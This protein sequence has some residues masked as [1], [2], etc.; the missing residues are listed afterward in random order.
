MAPWP[1]TASEWAF[2][3][4]FQR[5]IAWGREK[6][7][8]LIDT[9]SEILGTTIWAKFPVTQFFD[10]APAPSPLAV[11]L[12]YPPTNA[13]YLVDGLQRLAVATAILSSL[14]QR[15][16]LGTGGL[17]SIFPRLSQQISLGDA[18]IVRFN[19]HVLA[20]YPRPA[21][22]QQY[23]DF[24]RDMDSWVQE[25]C[26]QTSVWPAQV[27]AFFL[28]RQVGVDVYTG[29]PTPAA[30]ASNFVGIN[31]GSQQLGMEDIFRAQIVEDGLTNEW[32]PSDALNFDTALTDAL[33]E[34]DRAGRI[35]PLV[36]QLGKLTIQKTRTRSVPSLGKG[37]GAG[38]R[39]DT[40]E[41]IDR[42][43]P[44]CDSEVTPNPYDEAAI[45]ELY[46][47][48]KLPLSL[49]AA[50]DIDALRGAPWYLSTPPTAPTQDLLLLLRATYRLYIV[51][52]EGR[53][54][55]LLKALLEDDGA[56]SPDL[57]ALAEKISRA[58]T[59]TPA[60]TWKKVDDQVDPNWLRVRLEAIPKRRA[61][62]VFAACELEPAFTASGEPIQPRPATFQPQPFGT[63]NASL[64]I[65]HL[66]P[67]SSAGT[68][69]NAEETLRNFAP[70]P[71]ALNRSLTSSPCSAKLQG[72]P[73]APAGYK[74]LV[75]GKFK[76]K[77]GASSS[78]PHPYVEWL[79]NIHAPQYSATDLDDR[80]AL[81]GELGNERIKWLVDHLLVRL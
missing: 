59:E 71:T 36:T 46:S 61:A 9:P 10:P 25:E 67:T 5:G 54:T 6:V 32:T 74:I 3:P 45:E 38:L 43:R 80:T 58:A 72:F 18:A 28:D 37:N 11:H 30:L 7:D 12:N 53:Q 81:E 41:L 40:N 23:Q 15:G 4:T 70:I 22:A 55:D 51:G 66:I 47:C 69:S 76:P 73:G 26:A 20:N 57:D 27:E 50:H 16:A 2:V 35:T 34:S 60:G 42:L 52:L 79:V 44:Y 77:R 64:Q 63:K 48:G 1:P 49:I 29:Y 56:G 75:D 21:I 78:T 19:H 33:I 14:D 17:A 13:L 24:F 39:A 68:A 62:R 31:T 8:Q 65:D